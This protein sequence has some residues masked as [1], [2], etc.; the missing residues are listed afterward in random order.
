MQIK[1]IEK[2]EKKLQE[3]IYINKPEMTKEELIEDDEVQLLEG[4]IN[5]LKL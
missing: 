2:I 5:F 1:K 4:F 3:W